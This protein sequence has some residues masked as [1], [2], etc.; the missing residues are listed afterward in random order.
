MTLTPD[1]VLSLQ[2]LGVVHNP[3]PPTP[4]PVNPSPKKCFNLECLKCNFPGLW[5]EILQ[6]S[7]SQFVTIINYL[8]PWS[9]FLHQSP[10][11]WGPLGLGAHWGWGP[12]GFAC[13]ESIV[14]I[15]PEDFSCQG[16]SHVP[17]STCPT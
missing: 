7:D 4:P 14:V 9:M 5:G 16:E 1:L 11:L 10:R 15:T 13:S 6:N 2:K 17:I 12:P 3:P 8:R